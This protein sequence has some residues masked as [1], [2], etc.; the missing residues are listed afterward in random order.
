MGDLLNPFYGIIETDTYPHAR[1]LRTGLWQ[2]IKDTFFVFAGDFDLESKTFKK[3]HPGLLDYLFIGA[4]F[5]LPILL[6]GLIREE[7]KIQNKALRTIAIFFVGIIAIPLLIAKYIIAA[8]L[9][10][11]SL[12]IVMGVHLISLV[13]A[14][15][16]KERILNMPLLPRLKKHRTINGYLR[17]GKKD[18]DIENVEIINIV[19]AEKKLT[20]NFCKKYLPDGRRNSSRE[21]EFSYTTIFSGDENEIDKTTKKDLRALI[22]LNFGGVT[23][24]L[25]EIQ[26]IFNFTQSTKRALKIAEVTEKLGE[27][28]DVFNFIQS[29]IR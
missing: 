1:T 20:L 23:K 29:K 5:C 19:L 7:I 2:K 11:L 8:V 28:Q 21:P 17:N 26:D 24:K 25:E 13:M 27:T 9:T 14:S 3:L 16:M 6:V 10:Y 22:A 4:S 12:P 15:K 18:N